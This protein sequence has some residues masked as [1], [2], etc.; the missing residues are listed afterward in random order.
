ME[1]YSSWMVVY[2]RQGLAM[3]RPLIAVFL[4]LLIVVAA[5]TSGVAGIDETYVR[6]GPSIWSSDYYARLIGRNAFGKSVAVVIGVG[7]Y[8]RF[9][10]LSA[11]TGD[12]LR[13]RNFLRDEAGFD[14]IIMLTDDKATYARIAELMETTVPD[15]VG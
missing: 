6:P 11:P 15:V 3:R 9:R 1:V 7:D 8:D 5:Q 2:G 10:K 12:A 4:A 14:R 13:V